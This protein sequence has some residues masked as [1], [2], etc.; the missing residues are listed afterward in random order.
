MHTGYAESTNIIL[1][2]GYQERFNDIVERHE[3]RKYKN[4]QS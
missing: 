2:R 1:G 3:E 4:I